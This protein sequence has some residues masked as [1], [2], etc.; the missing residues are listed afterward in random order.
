[1]S[2]RVHYYKFVFVAFIHA[3]VRLSQ[4]ETINAIHIVCVDFNLVFVVI[5]NELI[6]SL[7]MAII[8]I[9]IYLIT[10]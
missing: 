3:H 1:M 4:K 8:T 2:V 6:Q 7:F 10:V 5:K 9:I